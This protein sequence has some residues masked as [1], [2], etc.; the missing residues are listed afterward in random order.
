M[1]WKPLTAAIVATLIGS[2]AEA[3]DIEHKYLQTPDGKS[4]P[5]IR[6]TGKIVGE[7]FLKFFDA[8]VLYA[9][10]WG[11]VYLES[12]GGSVLDAIS[13]GQQIAEAEWDTVVGE[14]STCASACG[15][16]WLAGKRRF[17]AE[18]ARIGFHAVYYTDSRQITSNGNAIV[19]AYLSKLG[20]GLKTISYVT[21]MP[22]DQMDWLSSAKAKE[23]DIAVQVLK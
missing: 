11:F 1:N 6:I 17:V 13:I 7:D 12:P 14:N 3:A 19:G 18:N 10:S 21:S 15:L 9:R 20:F 22:P 4:V 5:A 23:Y 16:I 2:T 8:R